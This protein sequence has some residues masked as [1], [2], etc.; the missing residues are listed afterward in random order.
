MKRTGIVTMLMLVI[1]AMIVSP[2]AAFSLAGGY[3]GPLTIKLQG[4]SR[5]QDPN[6]PTAPGQETWGIFRV[7]SFETNT[8]TL[9]QAGDDNEWIYG[10]FY[11]TTDIALIPS[12]TGVQ[13]NQAGGQFDLYLANI[14]PGAGAFDLDN[15]LT[16]RTAANQYD[17]ITNLAGATNFFSGD[18]APGIIPGDPN[19]TIRQLVGSG[20]APTTGVGSGYGDITGGDF[21]SLFNTNGFN[22]DGTPRDLFFNFDVDDQNLPDGWSQFI[23]DPVSANA[24]PEPATMVLFS[25][26]LIGAAARR[27]VKKA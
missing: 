24:V 12:G 17:S 7:T 14:A 1:G 3:Q 10:M 2:A 4:F 5:S 9:W 15:P 6:S 16:R 21:A 11:G 25:A 26:G 8:Q 13:I 20:T 19:T 18:F 27:K 22:P 23:N